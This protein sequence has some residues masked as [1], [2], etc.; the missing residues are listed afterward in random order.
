MDASTHATKK[1]EPKERRDDVREKGREKEAEGRYTGGND[2]DQS[3]Q[4]HGHGRD[5]GK[6][7]EPFPSPGKQPRG[8]EE[9]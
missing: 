6:V 8:E 7:P 3:R 2:S 5:D 1:G 9:E 4:A